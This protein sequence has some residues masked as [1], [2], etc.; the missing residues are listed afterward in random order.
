MGSETPKKEKKEKKEKSSKHSS[1]GVKKSKSEKKDKKER[2]EKK[3]KKRVEELIKA[4]SDSDDITDLQLAPV[5][6]VPFANPL[7]SASE[8]KL[9]LAATTRAAKNQSLKRGVKEVQ[10]TLRKIVDNNPASSGK[11]DPEGVVIIAAD[12]SPMDVISHLPVLCEDHNIPYIYITSRAS[13]GAA[14]ETKRSTSVVMIMRERFGKAASKVKDDDGSYD[15][16]FKKVVKQVKNA[17][18]SVLI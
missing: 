13:L 17:N 9:V 4:D 1:D 8:T 2:K 15:E 11:T 7:A 14:A 3:E 12:I 6:L 10:K 18:R 5:A 16:E